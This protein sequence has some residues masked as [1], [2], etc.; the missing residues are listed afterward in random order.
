MFRKGEEFGMRRG[1]VLILS[2][3]S[4][5]GKSTL[6]RQ[7]LV[8]SSGINLSVSTTTRAPRAGE[9]EGIDYYFCTQE[10]FRQ[11]V[12]QGAFLEWAAVFGHSYGTS[13]IVVEEALARGEDVLLDIDWQGA[14][15][16]RAG[17]RSGDVVSVF[18]SPPSRSKL[19]ERLRGRGK[20]SEEVIAGRMAKADDL[21]RA[22]VELETILQAERLRRLRLEEDA[23]EILAGFDL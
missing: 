7:L 18:I 22:H 6:A 13:R 3:P 8:S 14:R 20:D 10:K 16:V 21:T 15:Q 2:A 17:L 1:F 11:L 4:G 23:K 9:Q 5:A 19:E 12:V